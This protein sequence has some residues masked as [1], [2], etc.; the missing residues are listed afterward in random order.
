MQ[1]AAAPPPRFSGSHQEH[2][3][4]EEP[5]KHGDDQDE[6]VTLL[7]RGWRVVAPRKAEDSLYSS[8]GAGGSGSRAGEH[9]ARMERAYEWARTGQCNRRPGRLGRRRHG[10]P[11]SGL[12]PYPSVTWEPY[13]RPRVC[14]AAI[15][16]PPVVPNWSA[17]R[18]T[19]GDPGG[20]PDHPGQRRISGGVLLAISGPSVEKK[21]GEV[22]FAIAFLRP[23]RVDEG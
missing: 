2:P 11:R 23:E 13:L 9:A 5:A 19:D 15:N 21:S 7:R 16:L 10:V 14:V 4:G 18:E 17:R 6:V 12:E 1:T 22:V 3:S 8:H 20:E